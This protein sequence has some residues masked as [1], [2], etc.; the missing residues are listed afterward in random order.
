MS[1]VAGKTLLMANTL[2]RAPLRAKASHQGNEFMESTNIYVDN[3]IDNLPVST[4][5]MD[6]L[7]ENLRAGNV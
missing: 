4:T 1:H 2:L 3:V 5:Y 6:M 7:R